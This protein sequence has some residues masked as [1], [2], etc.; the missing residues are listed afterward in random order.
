MGTV[1]EFPKD[2][3]ARR[4]A[5]A[6]DGPATVVILPAIRIERH[7]DA[8]GTPEPERRASPGRGKRRRARS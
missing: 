6:C 2:A 7:D 4:E 8:A 5:R 1:I 3:A